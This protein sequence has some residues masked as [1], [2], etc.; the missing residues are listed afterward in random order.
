MPLPLDREAAARSL[1]FTGIDNAV[2]LAQGARG[3][4]EAA[5]LFWCVQY[6]HDLARLASDVILYAAEEFGFLVLPPDLATGSSIMPQK[7]NPDLFELTRARAGAVQGELAGVLAISGKLTGGYHRDFQLLKGPL[8]RGLE[9][10]EQM[11]SMMT[12]AIP[13]ITVDRERSLAALDG[14]TLATD[15]VMRR[16]RD[17]EPFRS[18]YRAV[19][20]A[21][22]SG[23]GMP[24][25]PPGEIIRA[26]QSVGSIGN[27]NLGAGRA[28]LR[29]ARA[30]NRRE[31]NRFERAMATLAGR[32]A[33]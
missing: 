18:A 22:K 10:T 25:L 11:L 32:R 21:V 33:R 24:V 14:P 17:G 26:R 5:V 13:R 7:R 20:A 4:L 16:V 3:K 27:M 29:A 1:G 31:R 19:A 6:G 8:M 23:K 12:F 2:T 9:A 30:W 15:E 28:R